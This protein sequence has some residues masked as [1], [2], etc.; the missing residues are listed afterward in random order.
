M[1]GAKEALHRMVSHPQNFSPCGEIEAAFLPIHR[2]RKVEL[3]V[4]S[5]ALPQFLKS[6]G[7]I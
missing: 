2:G 7:R 4:L 5:Q 3:V 6:K 1:S